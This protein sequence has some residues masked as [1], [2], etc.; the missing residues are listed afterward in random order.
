MIDIDTAF[1]RCPLIAILRGITPDEAIPVGEALVRA[2]FAMIEVPLNSPDPYMSIKALAAAFGDRVMIGAGTVMSPDDVKRV[3]GVSGRLIVMP[4]SDPAVISAAKA[5][6]LVCMP[7]VAT[8]TEGFAALALGA[9]GLKLFPA[10][11]IAP[12]V[13]K[14]WRAV[15]PRSVRLVMVGGIGPGEVAPYLTA[16]ANG[17][18]LGSSLYAPQRSVADIE[19]RA[20]ELVGAWRKTL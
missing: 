9:D 4:H 3:A 15:F 17:F 7:G 12:A 14:A 19:G 8:P 2:G 5:E 10:E 1:A 16:G 11:A 13:V 20:V 18:G 6:N